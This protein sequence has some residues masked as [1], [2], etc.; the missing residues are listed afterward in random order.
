MKSR[1]FFLLSL[2][3]FVFF[4]LFPVTTSAQ[5]TPDLAEGLTPYQS[6]QAGDFD[7][8]NLSNGNVLIRIPLLSYPQRGNTLK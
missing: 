7:A 4:G 8:V 3:A 6:F 1:L 5:I 2:T